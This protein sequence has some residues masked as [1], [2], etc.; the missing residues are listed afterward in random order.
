LIKPN[1]AKI[2]IEEEV[3]PI[4]SAPAYGA[5]GAMATKLKPHQKEG[6]D[7]LQKAWTSGLPGVLLADDMGLGKTLQG[8]AFLAWL[9]D[10]MRSG[11]VRRAPLLVVA[12]T[13]LLMN[14]RAEHDRH[15]EGDG[16]GLC[17]EAFGRGLAT[18]KR[19]TA[20]GQ[21]SLD[22]AALAEADWVLTTYETLRDYDRDFAKIGF[23]AAL[24][25]EA[26]KI[27]TPGRAHHR[28]GRSDEMR[29]PR[30]ADGHTGRKQAR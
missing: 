9:R 7:W 3:R 5:P 28:C 23:A 27:K 26:Q 25:D 29:I 10:G 19:R 6:L 15:L 20:D 16:L 30:S 18:L 8:L 11:A 22:E 13:G 1:E 21:P 14:W 12:P 4:R 2:E 17:T 24:F